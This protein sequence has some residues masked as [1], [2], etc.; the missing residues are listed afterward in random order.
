MYVSL[1]VC[2]FDCFYLTCLAN[3]FACVHAQDFM[4]SNVMNY[5][6]LPR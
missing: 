6:N 1:C 5:N 3:H 4:K 2:V